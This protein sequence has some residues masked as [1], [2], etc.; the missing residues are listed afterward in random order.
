MDTNKLVLIKTQS[1]FQHF[2]ALD[3]PADWDEKQIEHYLM[4]NLDAGII[5]DVN[6]KWI[7]EKVTEMKEIM[8]DDF[9]TFFDE[10]NAYLN[11]LPLFKKVGYI[12]KFV[13]SNQQ[14]DGK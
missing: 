14:N 1:Y 9:I 7:E 11:G 4:E 6:Q 12:H 10:E 8:L 2:Y 5:D 3:I 13:E